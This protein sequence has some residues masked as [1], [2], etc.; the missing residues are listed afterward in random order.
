MFK[1]QLL[2]FSILFELLGLAAKN[3]ILIV[4][5]A[6]LKRDQGM[7]A[8]DAAIEADRLRFRPILMTSM[9]F[10]LGVLPLAVASRADAASRHS[11]G[12]GVVGGMLS[13]TF[14]AVLFVPRFYTLVTA[15]D[16]TVG[17]RISPTAA[18]AEA[19]PP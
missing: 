14:L 13:A 8:V 12:T 3:G 16:R 15:R 5:F 1:L 7:T 17:A 4:E 9:A 2:K 18:T 10:I 11:I 6:V 19:G